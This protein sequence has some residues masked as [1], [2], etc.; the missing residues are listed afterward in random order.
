VSE[1]RCD[2]REG[3]ATTAPEVDHE[4]FQALIEVSRAINAGLEWNDVLES[5]MSVTTRVM[6]VEASALMLLNEA[7]T[8]LSFQVARGDKAAA[9]KTIRVKVGEGIAGWVAREWKPA[10]VNDV[11]SDPRF[12]GSTDNT[13]GFQTRAILCV[14]LQTRA[15]QLGVIEVINRLDRRDFTEKDVVL[16]EAI[17]A[18]VAISLE[19]ARLHEERIKRER[20]AAVGQTVAGL[21]HCIK[22]ILNAV[23]GGAYILD[24][25]LNK[26]DAQQVAKGWDTVKRNN[27][28]LSQL[29]LDMLSYSKEREPAYAEV[30]IN[31]VCQSVLR[32]CGEVASRKNVNLTFEAAWAGGQ[33]RVDETGIKRCLMNLLGNAV[34]ACGEEDGRVRLSTAAGEDGFFVIRIEDNGCGISEEAKAKLFQVFFSTKGSKGTGLGLPVTHKIIT[35]HRGRIDVESAPGKGT[36]FVIALPCRPPDREGAD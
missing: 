36:A 31:D 21:A 5:V 3:E 20:L 33:V 14:P 19:N 8:E 1:R 22:N 27:Q 26:Q 16:C 11:R 30:D 10:V 12:T 35:E 7:G 25:G 23:A 2:G 32:M 28:F 9:V 15:R 18:Q 13:T 6:K 17:A 4:A 29:V 24:A 34:D